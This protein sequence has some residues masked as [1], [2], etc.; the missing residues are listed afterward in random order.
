ML[1]TRFTVKGL[2][3][4][5]LLFLPAVASFGKELFSLPTLYFSTGHNSC[6]C[7]PSYRNYDILY[8]TWDIAN[9]YIAFV[10]IYRIYLICSQTIIRSTI[11][12]YVAFLITFKAP[13]RGL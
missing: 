12:G 7:D 10:R 4:D 3:A 11:C 1:P 5:F 2:V 6:E 13:P 8:Q 9:R